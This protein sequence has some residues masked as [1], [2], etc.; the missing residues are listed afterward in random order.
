MLVFSDLVF[1]MLDYSSNPN[2]TGSWYYWDMVWP[3]DQKQTYQRKTGIEKRK[4]IGEEGTG[5]TD[6]WRRRGDRGGRKG[7]LRAE[8]W[9]VQTEL[10]RKWWGGRWR[11]GW[12]E[13]RKLIIPQVWPC[14]QSMVSACVSKWEYT[15]F[16]RCPG[17]CLWKN[18]SVNFFPTLSKLCFICYL[19]SGQLKHMNNSPSETSLKYLHYLS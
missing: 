19:S 1:V 10:E 11:K 15:H 6:T 18:E 5:S 14:R 17:V 9:H 4:V 2:K 7:K 16:L 12:R 13:Q 3:R 8:R